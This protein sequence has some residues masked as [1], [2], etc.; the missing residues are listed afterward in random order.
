M[1][2][3]LKKYGAHILMTAHHGDDLAETILMRIS[4]G[5]TLKGYS[6]FEQIVDMG[7]YKIVRPLI[8]ATK[9]ELMEL[10]SKSSIKSLICFILSSKNANI[11][12]MIPQGKNICNKKAT[13]QPTEI[14]RRCTPQNDTNHSY[15]LQFT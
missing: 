2:K 12:Y 5:S 1:E 11:L 4:R 8:H 13:Y 3:T 14:L 6:G 7:N 10:F 9:D 15:E